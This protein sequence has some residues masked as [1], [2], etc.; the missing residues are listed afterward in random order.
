MRKLALCVLGNRNSGKSHTW[1]KLFESKVS[2]SKKERF[3]FL[4]E[5]S[6]VKVFLING[7]P[8]ERKKHIKT[9]VGENQP[10]ILLCSI[11]YHPSA[12]TT[13]QYLLE[14]EYE[15]VF[16]WLNPGFQ[17]NLAQI[18]PD[19][20][21]LIEFLSNNNAK[22]D[23]VDGKTN[24]MERVNLIKRELYNWASENGLLESSKGKY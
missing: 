8:E 18:Q 7:S 5:Y 24:I 11:Q 16:Y 4:N 2:T 12:S 21:K 3:L 6:A 14:Q 15:L 17:D 19:K 20:L 9:I 10:R 1:E 23:V 22:I 13:L